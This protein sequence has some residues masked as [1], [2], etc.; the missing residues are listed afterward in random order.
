MSVSYFSH[1][2]KTNTT[3]EASKI[4][5]AYGLESIVEYYEMIAM[6]YHNGQ[7]AQA[8]NQFKKLGKDQRAGFVDYLNETELGYNGF[9]DFLIITI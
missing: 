9:K 6:S 2:S 1:N 7:K 5:K 4:L 8:L 3:M